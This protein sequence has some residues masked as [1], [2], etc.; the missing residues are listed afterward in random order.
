MHF[1]NAGIQ[2]FDLKDLKNPEIAAYF[3][4]KMSGEYPSEDGKKM[5]KSDH[6]NPVHSVLVEWDRNLI[7]AFS[8]HGIYVLSSPLL[9]SN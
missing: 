1:Y 6:S 5:I 7:W 4:P 8:N 9:S 2:I 3:V